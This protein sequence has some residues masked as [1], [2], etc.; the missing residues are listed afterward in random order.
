MDL[1]RHDR[2]SELLLSGH[3]ADAP[4]LVP[5]DALSDCVPTPLATACLQLTAGEGTPGPLNSVAK[6]TTLA[7]GSAKHPAKASFRVQPGLCGML[8]VRVRAWLT[9]RQSMRRWPLVTRSMCPKR[10]TPATAAR[11]A[12][13]CVFRGEWVHYGPVGPQN[14]QVTSNLALFRQLDNQLRGRRSDGG[15]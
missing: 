1:T 6:K 13:C 7:G 11:I 15:Q 10:L 8:M 2:K 14:G 4:V 12:N 3:S 9:D 5:R